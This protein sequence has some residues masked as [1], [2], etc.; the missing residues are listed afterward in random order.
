[1]KSLVQTGIVATLAVLL[2][3]G[4]TF[5]SDYN[6][7]VVTK[8]PSAGYTN[9]E[10][11]SGWYLRGDIGYSFDQSQEVTFARAARSGNANATLDDTYSASVGFGH[12]FN[13]YLRADATFDIFSGRDWS[14]SAS[15][16][17]VDGVGVPFTGDCT[18]EDSGSFEAHALSVNG[19]VNL[20]RW[21]RL[22]PYVGAG[23][24]LAHVEY[25]TTNSVLNCVVDP[26]ENC[27]LGVHSGA[28]ANPETFT[29]SQEFAGGTSV[30]LTYALM[31]GMDYR[32][33][34][35]WSADLGYRYTNITGSETFSD[36]CGTDSVEFDGVEIH[37]VRGGLRYDLW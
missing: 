13:D 25:S 17:G 2:T 27:D 3:S 36:C 29:G 19:Y 37:E 34:K 20:G 9:V 31:L 23:V 26:G 28:T 1:M 18:S 32:I 11:G 7:G 33:D 5:A 16:C 8:T 12:I 35:N 22:S 24:G 15:G 4:S 6:S 10:F 21:G 14:G 30:N